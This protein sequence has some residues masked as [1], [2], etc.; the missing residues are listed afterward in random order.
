MSKK[1]G[2]IKLK[3]DQ[4]VEYLSNNENKKNKSGSMRGK[5]E[6]WNF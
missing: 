3:V 4:I 6:E 5:V 1:K 2:I